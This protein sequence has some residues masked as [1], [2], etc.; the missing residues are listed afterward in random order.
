[1]DKKKKYLTAS[2]KLET[3]ISTLNNSTKKQFTPSST[4]DTT[5]DGAIGYFLD[6]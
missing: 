4:F 1:M 6:P 2:Q 3:S 5:Y